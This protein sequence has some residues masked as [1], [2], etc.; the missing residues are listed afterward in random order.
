M[1]PK[2]LLFTA[3]MIVLGACTMVTRPA[4]PASPPAYVTAL[5]VAYGPPSQAAFGSAVFYDNTQPPALLEQAALAKYQYFTGDLW[6][7]YGADAWLGTWHNVY[8]RP[9]S[10]DRAVVSE[11]RAIKDRTAAQ[12]V[13]LLLDEAEDPQAA[14]AAL[15]TAFDDPAVTEL[16]VYTIGDGAAMS[17]ILLAARRTARGET[18]MLVFLLD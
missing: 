10:A 17:G 13:E 5:A 3:L 9:T 4:Q 12:S 1:L 18:V 11:L 7:R 8:S 2:T 14:Q 16:S 6:D 15:S